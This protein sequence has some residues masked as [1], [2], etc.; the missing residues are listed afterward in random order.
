[1]R[2]RST[3]FVA[4]LLVIGMVAAACTGEGSRSEATAVPPTPDASATSSPVSVSVPDTAPATEAPPDS[5]LSDSGPVGTD[6]PSEAD[7]WALAYTGGTAGAARGEPITIGYVNQEDAFPEN[8]VGVEAA[9]AYVNAE[10]G[11]VAGRPLVLEACRITVASDGARCGA[12]LAADADVVAVLAGTT[13]VGNRELYQALDGIKPVVVGN[14]VTGA[15]FTTTA[16]HALTAGSLGVILGLG[17][18]VVQELDGVEVAA[19][20]GPNDPAG[21]AASDLLL[22]PVLTEAGVA[23]TYVGIGF[24][25][26]A[27]DVSAALEASGTATPDVIV[28]LLTVDQCIAVRDAITAAATDPA[29]ITTGLCATAPM[30]EHLADVGETGPVPNGWYVGG[31][32]YNV[33][34]PDV[35]S[36][37]LTYVT[38]LQAFGT[39]VPGDERVDPVGLTGP[40]FAAVL[41]LARFINDIAGEQRSDGV[42]T[43]VIEPAAVDAELR[44]FTGPMMMQAG[45]LACGRQVLLGLSIFVAPCASQVGVQRYVDGE[46][47]SVRDGLDGDPIDVTAL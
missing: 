30:A 46:W 2:A 15:D 44:S 4:G 25:A 27:P 16:G 43:V 6:P 33:F 39:P 36:G 14:G 26:S 3:Q 23:T 38:A 40:A 31:Y 18:F 17:G 20:L 10:L 21:R 7:A 5:A 1:M 35:D 32:G 34:E 37:M 41:T 47:I 42:S 19:V 24:G 45:P 12:Q 8:T 22:A 28:A 13:L 29:V 11:G 9:V